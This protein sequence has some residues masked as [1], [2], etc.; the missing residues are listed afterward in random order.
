MSAAVLLHVTLSGTVLILYGIL[1]RLIAGKRIS[2]LFFRTLWIIAALRL[3]IL[4]PLSSPAGQLPAPGND[5]FSTAV[6]PLPGI[7]PSGGGTVP[8]GKDIPWLMLVWGGIALIL[9]TRIAVRHGIWLHRMKSTAQSEEITPM[10]NIRRTVR[11]CVS[12]EADSPCTAGIFR[13][14][15]VLPIP[16]ADYES[17]TLACILAHESAHIRRLDAAVR[18]LFS[19]VL[20]L[21]WFNPFVYI[22]I[23]LAN[24]D[25][26][27]VCDAD[28]LALLGEERRTAYAKALLD[29]AEARTAVLSLAGHSMRE[30][31]I[32][33]MKINR[34][35]APAA[36][37]AAALCIGCAA[38]FAASPHSFTEIPGS[39]L[40]I[41]AVTLPAE[42]AAS[43]ETAVQMPP[44]AETDSPAVES[45]LF[46]LPANTPWEITQPFGYI[47]YAGVSHFH[48]GTDISAPED[49]V[50]LAALSGTVIT[51]EYSYET[52]NHIVVETA[53]GIRYEYR[54]CARL[55]A[56]AGDTVQR[57]DSI[58][59]IGQTGDA[60]GIHLHFGV[61][62]DGASC[63]PMGM[64]TRREV[65]A[66]A[67]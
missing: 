55:L 66:S 19:A 10:T 64:F 18:V 17:S 60:T 48:N 39:D 14:M 20:C 13:P 54:H 11:L 56:E 61:E 47:S 31:I 8:A 40:P 34:Y 59:V 9:A 22:M 50:L 44:A 1:M 4:T 7:L 32:S 30:R 27:R 57:G 43:A 21:H 46:P 52:G 28:A 42:T 35:S 23:R 26:E 36:A 5:G 58:A 49:T 29:L 37:I 65:T 45:W 38:V 15:I 41:S 51:A 12:P 16:A 67:E 2:P 63:D 24:C 62:T 3:L 53:G 25:L 33:I 6:L